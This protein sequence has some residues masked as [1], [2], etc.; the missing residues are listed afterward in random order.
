MKDL[1]IVKWMKSRFGNHRKKAFIF[2]IDGTLSEKSP[3]RN[4][5]EVERCLTDKLIE[6]T[7]T[8]YEALKQDGYYIIIL[9]GRNEVFKEVTETWLEMHDIE[10]DELFMRPQFCEDY[11]GQ[12]KADTYLHQIEPNYE[13][14]SVFEDKPSVVK[15]LRE[16]GLHV[17]QVADGHEDSPE[18]FNKYR[19][20]RK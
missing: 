12:F 7:Y 6:G 10:Y 9:T 4:P 17:C 16:I 8:I 2:D 13:V 11:D 18:M 3:N 1:K 20:E 5:F 14:L 15:A 19:Q